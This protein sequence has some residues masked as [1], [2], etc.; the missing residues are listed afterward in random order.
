MKKPMPKMMAGSAKKP[1]PFA[2]RMKKG[3]MPAMGK[4]DMPK[5]KKG[6]RCK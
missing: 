4:P 3:A 5:F 2:A 1:A 6:G